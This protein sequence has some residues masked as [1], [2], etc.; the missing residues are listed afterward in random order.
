MHTSPWLIAAAEELT[1]LAQIADRDESDVWRMA[2]LAARLLGAPFAPTPSAAIL[3]ILAHEERGLS[4][5]C[6]P[7]L[8][9]QLATALADNDDPAGRLF[10]TLLDI[11]DACS[12]AATFGPLADAPDLARRAEALLSVWPQRTLALGGF[13]SMRLTTLRSDAIQLALWAAVERSPAGALAEAL[14][15]SPTTRSPGISAMA[16]HPPR[17]GRPVRPGILYATVPS[18]LLQAAAWTSGEAVQL[19]TVV[20]EL[21]LE[22]SAGRLMLEARLEPGERVSIEVV[23]RADGAVLLEEAVAGVL[24][25]RTFYAELGPAV[26]PGSRLLDCVRRSGAL[27]DAV[28]VRFRVSGG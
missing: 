6:G 18:R 1:A 9:N 7:E 10:D 12:V 19:D 11:D 22:E 28:I 3:S 27:L 26:G 16:T 2:V 14:P 5:P 15:A 25:G 21:W 23:R 24:R 13:A 20:G 8:L 4:R 17:V